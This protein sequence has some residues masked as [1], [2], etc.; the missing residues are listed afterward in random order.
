MT[1]LS[2]G[3]QLTGAASRTGPPAE[4]TEGMSL[5]QINDTGQDQSF[6]QRTPLTQSYTMGTVPEQIAQHPWASEQ[7]TSMAGQTEA[8]RVGDALKPHSEAQPPHVHRSV[9]EN[10]TDTFRGQGNTMLE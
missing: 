4:T 10:N 3:S 1:L 8:A 2:A 6:D 9:S 5:S 7:D